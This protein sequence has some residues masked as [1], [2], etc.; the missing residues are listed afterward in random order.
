MTADVDSETSDANANKPMIFITIVLNG[1]PFMPYHITVFKAAAAQMNTSW[2][3]HIVEGVAIGRADAEAP[4]STRKLSQVRSDG[5]STDGT[6]EFIASL[7]EDGSYSYFSCGLVQRLSTLLT[8]KM[9]QIRNLIGPYF[10]T[11]EYSSTIFK[12]RGSA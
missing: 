5:C 11:S 1:M 9:V 2:E 10:L 4:Y 6:N 8:S 7:L 12:R 3:W